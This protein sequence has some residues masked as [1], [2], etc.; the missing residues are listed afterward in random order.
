MRELMTEKEFKFFQEKAFKYILFSLIRNTNLM[1]ELNEDQREEL[2]NSVFNIMINSLNPEAAIVWNE[3]IL[4][5]SKTAKTQQS[6][7]D[8]KNILKSDFNKMNGEKGENE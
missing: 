2:L 6:I 4:D 5:M 8:V 1:P 3:Q 7:E